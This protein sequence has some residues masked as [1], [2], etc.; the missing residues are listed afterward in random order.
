MPKFGS[1]R[2]YSLPDIPPK[3]AIIAVCLWLGYT[4][5]ATNRYKGIN[6]TSWFEETAIGEDIRDFQV[7]TQ[8]QP[9]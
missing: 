3:I 5:L 2:H 6:L 8:C 7:L 4:W 1:R 9:Q